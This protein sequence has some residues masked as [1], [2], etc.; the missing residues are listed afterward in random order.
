[1][2]QLSIRERV[3]EERDPHPPKEKS[4]RSDGDRPTGRYVHSNPMYEEEDRVE[5]DARNE[6]GRI[7]HMIGDGVGI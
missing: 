1:M 5:H 4:Q 3:E 6:V 7:S 2:S